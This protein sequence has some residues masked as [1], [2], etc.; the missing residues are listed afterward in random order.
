MTTAAHVRALLLTL[1]FLL[2]RPDDLVIVVGLVNWL[3]MAVRWP[4]QSI[5]RRDQRARFVERWSDAFLL[6]LSRGLE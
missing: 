2:L 5:G 6:S 3:G 1:G 4:I